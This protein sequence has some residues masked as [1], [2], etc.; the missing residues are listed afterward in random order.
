M[1]A[2]AA[3]GVALSLLTVLLAPSAAHAADAGD[4]LVCLAP[5][6]RERV[7]EAAVLLKFATT[8]STA[9]V[10]RTE[11]HGDLPLDKWRTKDD[12]AFREACAAVADAVRTETGGGGGGGSSLWTTMVPLLVGAGL[13]LVTTFLTSG[14]RERV[15]EARR[16]GRVLRAAKA[17]FLQET[18]AFLA[19][20]SDRQAPVPSSGRLDLPRARLVRALDEMPDVES[21]AAL[22]RI[23]LAVTTGELG[24]DLT[25]NWSDA[26]SRSTSSPRYLQIQAALADADRDIERG[27]RTRERPVRTSLLRGWGRI[28]SKPVPT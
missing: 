6:R 14:W 15:N 12:A 18:R 25:R 17:E 3:T 26:A 28:R 20:V 8:G 7:V 11:K 13:T 4:S 27:I 22:H 19:D 24:G 23:R 5:E 10:M 21:S 16:Q 2:V 9:A 1:R